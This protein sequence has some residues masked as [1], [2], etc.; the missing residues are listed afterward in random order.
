MTPSVPVQPDGHARRARRRSS[1]S[2]PP[3]CSRSSR[4]AAT[5]RSPTS[6][7]S[8]TARSSSSSSSCRSRTP[9]RRPALA[10]S[11]LATADPEDAEVLIPT[12]HEPLPRHDARHG[13]HR[14]DRLRERLA[15]GDDGFRQTTPATSGPALLRHQRPRRADRRPPQRRQDRP[16]RRLHPRRR[17]RGADSTGVGQP[18]VSR[19]YVAFGGPDGVFVYRNTDATDPEVALTAPGAR[20]DGLRDGDRRPRP[21]P[22]RAGSSRSSSAPTAARSAS[23]PPPT[24]SSYSVVARHRRS[25]PPASTCSTRSRPMAAAGRRSARRADRRAG[26]ARPGEDAPPTV[27]FTSPAAGAHLSGTPDAG[28]HRRRRPRRRLRALPGRRARRLHR[29]DRALRVRVPPDRRRRRPHDARRGGDR[30]RRPDRRRLRERHASTASPPRSLSAKTTPRTDRRRPFRF[31]T[32]RRAAAA[33]RRH[34]QAGL[35]QRRRRGADQGGAQDDLHPPRGA[36]HA[37]AATARA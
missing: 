17:Q 3:P 16:A 24:R 4:P 8:S 29:H 20:R 31:T 30:Q 5:T 14:R 36:E 10:V 34:A 9:T 28:G 12:S 32:T 23:T 13:P 11:Q 22:T 1:T 35:R 15:A 33:G 18:A 25:W 26:Q 27:A 21:R 7:T 6:C 37:P 2:R 19:G